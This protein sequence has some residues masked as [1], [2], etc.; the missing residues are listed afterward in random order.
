[1]SS[2]LYRAPR[3]DEVSNTVPT[4]KRSASDVLAT[5]LGL[6]WLLAAIVGLHG[7]FTLLENRRKR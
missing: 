6:I 4:L 3:L 7:G 5:G 2:L 1:M